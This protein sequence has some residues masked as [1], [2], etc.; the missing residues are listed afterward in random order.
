MQ[1]AG[2]PRRACVCDDVENRKVGENWYCDACDSLLGDS[3]YLSLQEWEDYCVEIQSPSVAAPPHVQTRAGFRCERF[4]TRKEILKKTLMQT[5]R[6]ITI[7]TGG[8]PKIEHLQM[9]IASG[10]RN[11]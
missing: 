2:R 1:L 9:P 4:Y 10:D 6:M 5:D 11:F 8:S 3:E 7:R